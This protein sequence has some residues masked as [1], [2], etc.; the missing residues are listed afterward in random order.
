MG[1]DDGGATEVMGEAA[2][3]LGRGV[4]GSGQE[5]ERDGDEGLAGARC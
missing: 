2:D 1:E 5:R 3:M 4:V